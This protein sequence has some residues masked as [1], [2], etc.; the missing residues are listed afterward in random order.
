M[1]KILCLYTG[2]GINIRI[3]IFIILK[4]LLYGIVTGFSP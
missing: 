1:A 3:M 4:T 2:L